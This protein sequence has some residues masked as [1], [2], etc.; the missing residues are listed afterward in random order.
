VLDVATGKLVNC[1]RIE[2]AKASAP[3]LDNEK[4]YLGA[5]DGCIYALKL[6]ELLTPAAPAAQ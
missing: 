3:A 6:S 2:K 4:A 5:G 1:L